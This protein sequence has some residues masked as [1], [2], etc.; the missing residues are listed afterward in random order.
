MKIVYIAKHNSGDNDDEGAISYALRELGHEVVCIQENDVV[1]SIRE[2]GDVVLVHKYENFSI[3]A[4]MQP[5]IVTWDFDAVDIDD[6]QLKDRSRIRIEL[7]NNREKFSKLCLHTDGDWVDRNPDKRVQLMQGADERYAGYGKPLESQPPIIFTGTVGHGERRSS[8]IES[9]KSHYGV[10]FAVTGERPRSKVHGRALAHRLASAKIAIAP[11]GPN[12]HK[13]WSNRVYLT[14]GLGGFLIHPY[15]DRLLEH[16]DSD[17]LVTYKTREELI[18]LIDFYLQDNHFREL[19]RKRG[20]ERTFKNHLYRH[21]CEVLVQLINE[22][23][24]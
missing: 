16:Y 23:V 11:D 12:T 21:R 13:Y 6:P 8:H 9:L 3:M 15:C 20:H 24:L 7:A 2:D 5:P 14:L 17:E 19:M 4:R 10:R 1:R 18:E 22:R